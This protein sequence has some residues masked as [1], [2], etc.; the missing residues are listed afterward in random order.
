MESDAAFDD[1]QQQE[2]ETSVMHSTTTTVLDEASLQQLMDSG[3]VGEDS[4]IAIVQN[5]HGEPQTVAERY[6]YLLI[7]IDADQLYLTLCISF[8]LDC[9]WC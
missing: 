6:L 4:I 9:R 8:I 7:Q 3:T 1:M 2:E 5:E